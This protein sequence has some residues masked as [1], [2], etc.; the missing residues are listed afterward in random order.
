MKKIL[1]KINFLVSFFAA[2]SSLFCAFSLRAEAP[3]FQSIGP[4][5]INISKVDGFELGKVTKVFQSQDGFI[6]LLSAQ[7]GLV[8]F[9]GTDVKQYSSPKNLGKINTAIEDQQGL[10][11]LGFQGEEVRLFDKRSETFIGL[12]EKFGT[13]VDDSAAI[14]SVVDMHQVDGEIWLLTSNSL[15]K[16]S[17]S[18]G[19]L[20]IVNTIYSSPLPDETEYVKTVHHEGAIWIATA[21]KGAFRY[22]ADGMRHFQHEVDNLNSINHNYIS[23]VKVSVSGDIWFGTVNGL[24]VYNPVTSNFTRH[25]PAGIGAAKYQNTISS[26]LSVNDNELWVGAYVGG[27]FKLNIATHVFSQLSVSEIVKDTL[28][29]NQVNHLFKASDNT[30]WVATTQGVSL[31]PEQFR[32]MTRHIVNGEGSCEVSNIISLDHAQIRF[33]CGKD[34]FSYDHVEQQTKHIYQ[35]TDT[36]W[37]MAALDH[38]NG[39]IIALRSG[40]IIQLDASGV[41]ISYYFDSTT[42]PNDNSPVFGFETA[43][44]GDIFGIRMFNTENNLAGGIFKYAKQNNKISFYTTE[45]PI[46]AILPLS[47]GELLVAEE[48]SKKLKLLN[49]KTMTV[50]HEFNSQHDIISFAEPEDGTVWAGTKG[51]G[52][53]ALDLVSYQFKQLFTDTSEVYS[54]LDFQLGNNEYHWFADSLHLFTYNVSND[55]PQCVS[56]VSG[57]PE[58]T[59]M[60]RSSLFFINEEALLVGTTNSLLSLPPNSTMIQSS[61]AATLNITELKIFN[62]TVSHK[63]ENS[64][65]SRAIEYTD[66]LTLTHDQYLFSLRFSAVDFVSSKQQKYAYQLQG[67]DDNWV[68]TDADNPVATYTTLPSGNYTFKV[69]TVPSGSQQTSQEA[70]LDIHIL[71]P[72]WLTWQAYLG[73]ILIGLMAVYLTIKYRTKSL[74]LRAQALERGVEQKTLELTVKSK[75]IESLLLDKNRLFANVSHEFR[76]P[77]TLILSSLNEKTESGLDNGKISASII[78]NSAQRLLKM[79]EQLLDFASLEHHQKADLKHYNVRQCIEETLAGFASVFTHKNLTATTNITNEFWVLMYDDALHKVLANLLSNSSKYIPID[80]HICCTVTETPESTIKIS[81]ADSGEGISESDKAVIFQ[82]FQRGSRGNSHNVPGTGIG[83]ALVKELVEAHNGTVHIDE[84]YTNGCKIDVCLPKALIT[85]SFIHSNISNQQHIGEMLTLHTATLLAAEND[86]MPNQTLQSV[87]GLPIALIIEDNRALQTL[88]HRTLSPYYNCVHAFDGQEGLQQALDIVPDVIISDVMMPHKD[89]F[90]VL[91]TVRENQ[92]TSHI[93]F[94][95]LTAKGDDESKIQGWK[96]LADEYIVKPFEKKTLVERIGNLIALRD[97]LRRKFGANIALE[98]LNS[99]QLEQL[100]ARD[101]DFIESFEQQ[102][103]Q[104]YHQEQLSRNLI[105]KSLR[106][107]ERQLN[108]KLAALFDY[109]FSEYVRRFRLRKSLS[110]IGSGLQVAQISDAVGFSSPAYFSACFKAEFGKT[111]KSY[112]KEMLSEVDKV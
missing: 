96:S 20:E 108:R 46:R 109:N 59:M 66:T 83:L 53:F 28:P 42:A 77:L 10:I 95:M 68:M 6:W 44:N 102:I 112:E 79:V 23:D 56:C 87:Q 60:S 39:L 62:Q 81:I 76:T 63:Q 43:A 47:N 92:K 103:E 84:H 2:L 72:P 30:L 50:K 70:T 12:A 19:K 91:K 49:T 94:V 40:D 5:V 8:R 13:V 45:K 21:T 16:V 104:Y 55:I 71:P 27:L 111:V 98:S 26:I 80:G 52:I 107:S 89:G 25:Y 86:T 100:G 33:S 34:L 32:S 65:L 14:T 88:L 78:K 29:T 38:I 90:E 67:L 99:A 101:R 3:R 37:A 93:P 85:D 18:S 11:W 24:A 1:I 97:M 22:S 61:K 48:V 41:V 35:A 73:Y 7:L 64:V 54:F 51:S 82:R 9:D 106:M 36:I 69:K 74:T 31:I 105:A 110:L 58:I 57:F 4:S 75:K 15:A 17:T